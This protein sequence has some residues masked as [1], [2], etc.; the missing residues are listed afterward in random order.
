MPE[1]GQ[2][3]TRSEMV[4]KTYEISMTDA[5]TNR[6]ILALHLKYGWNTK[7]SQSNIDQIKKKVLNTCLQN[8]YRKNEAEYVF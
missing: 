5:K 7:F 3:E 4:S 1:Y 6:G 2:P 8:L